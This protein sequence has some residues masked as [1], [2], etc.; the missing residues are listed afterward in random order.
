L[1]T[2]GVNELRNSG[3]EEYGYNNLKQ[4]LI[5]SVYNSSESVIK[6]IENDLRSYAKNMNQHDDMTVFLIT[7]D[8]NEN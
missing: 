8:K 6:I 5:S 2:D 4:I 7:Y 3:N 1:I